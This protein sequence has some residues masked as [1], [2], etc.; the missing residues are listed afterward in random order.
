MSYY[1][2]I[3]N[4]K[5][6]CNQT[7]SVESFNPKF[8]IINKQE[9]RNVHNFEYGS[10]FVLNNLITSKGCL[11]HCSREEFTIAY[12][13]IIENLYG[14]GP[15]L[16]DI[17]IF[18]NN[19]IITKPNDHFQEPQCKPF[20]STVGLKIFT[21]NG[22]II[23]LFKFIES[24]KIK[25]FNDKTGGLSDGSARL[26]A[27]GNDSN[28]IYSTDELGYVATF[29]FTSTYFHPD[30]K[31]KKVTHFKTHLIKFGRESGTLPD[32]ISDSYGNYTINQMFFKSKRF[33]TQLGI[34]TDR[35][36]PLTNGTKE[37]LFVQ[38]VI[39]QI[40]N[41][42]APNATNLP[43]MINIARANNIYIEP[44]TTGSGSGSGS[45]SGLGL[46]LRL[47]FRLRLRLG[48]RLRL[49]LRVRLC[50]CCPCCCCPCCCCP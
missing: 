32:P 36:I 38:K 40:R 29:R 47:R 15:L 49:R 21:H 31:D 11:D 7:D 46:R 33:A 8:Y 48:L 39:K 10:T 4:I 41:K 3:F 20:N 43:T 37:T 14:Y 26:W 25:Q 30:K 23:Y 1:K 13:D 45:G 50:P 22:K 42:W 28:T 27:I 6:M 19:E 24:N 18:V 2:V 5:K 34:T 12:K 35:Q 44:A 16:N 9:Y 17:S